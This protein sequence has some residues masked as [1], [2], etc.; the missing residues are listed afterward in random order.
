MIGFA[1]VLVGQAASG[2]T[3][4]S[5]RHAVSAG[6][7]VIVLIVPGGPTRVVGRWSFVSLRARRTDACWSAAP[8]VRAVWNPAAQVPGQPG[9]TSPDW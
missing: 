9:L 8:G 1:A 2:G 6:G 5:S 7:W 3:S 4:V